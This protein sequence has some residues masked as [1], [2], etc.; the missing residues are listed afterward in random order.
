MTAGMVLLASYFLTTL[1]RL[2]KGL[3]PVARF[4]PISYY[5]SGEAIDGLNGRWLLGLLA[6][7]ALFTVLAW[8]CFQLRDIRVV[9]ERGWRWAFRRRKG[10]ASSPA[11]SRSSGTRAS[12]E[13]LERTDPQRP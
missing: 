5:Q 2:D 8:W 1:A 9:G 7:A 11:R 13:P 10:A 4:S 6:A 3:E 12:L